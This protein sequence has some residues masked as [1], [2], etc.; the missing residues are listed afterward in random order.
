VRAG[1]RVGAL[2]G[3]YERSPFAGESSAMIAV[4]EPLGT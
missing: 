3:D 2:Y 1:F 4:A